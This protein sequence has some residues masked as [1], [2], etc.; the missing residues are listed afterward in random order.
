MCPLYY[1]EERLETSA[2][3]SI[4]SCADQLGIKVPTSCGR[5]GTCHECLVEITRGMAALSPP[6]ESEAFLHDGYRLACQARI[7]DP[8]GD[9]AFT[10]MK[11]R[12]QIV[13]AGERPAITLNPPVLHV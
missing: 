1:G 6:G 5:T 12:R 7:L 9:V 2:G 8:D 10:L 3:L 4:F 11:R 13:T